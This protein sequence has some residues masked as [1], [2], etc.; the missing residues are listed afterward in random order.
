MIMKKNLY[1]DHLVVSKLL[2]VLIV[3]APIFSFSQKANRL[4]LGVHTGWSQIA[5]DVSSQP[6][7]GGG[8]SLET[9]FDKNFSMRLDYTGSLNYG[10]DTRF[11]PIGS[12][13]HVGSRDPWGIYYGQSNKMFNANHRSTIHQ[14]S[15]NGIYNFYKIQ[16]PDLPNKIYLYTT[17]GYSLL[18]T[19]V[20]VNALNGSNL[21]YDFAS[22]NI[23]F[24]LSKSEVKK[25]IRNLLD[26]SYESN[27]SY[28]DQT[29]SKAKNQLLYHGINLGFGIKYDITDKFGLAAEFRTT[30]GFT[31]YLDGLSATTPRDYLN[32]FS[33]KLTYRLHTYARRV[34]KKKSVVDGVKYLRT[35]SPIITTEFKLVEPTI[36]G[37]ARIH[38]KDTSYYL[39]MYFIPTVP[40]YVNKQHMLTLRLANKQ[41]ILL[42][43]SEGATPLKVNQR[44]EFVAGLSV[45]ALETLSVSPV[46]NFR[47]DNSSSVLEDKIAE[48]DQLI[49]AQICKELLRFRK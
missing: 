47:I 12:L 15:L 33:A 27:A 21:P 14:F 17:L 25:Q 19:D 29:G 8:I 20:D 4:L 45:D 35:S 18:M 7:L 48:S 37:E 41:L 34:E 10:L 32:Y 46:T 31:D 43:Y 28:K 13:N 36:T 26:K 16:L 39:K 1:A 44:F 6:G 5:G 38:G 2:I 49:I 11:R 40:G 3:C 24:T 9:T 30:T 22:S 42:P 23:D